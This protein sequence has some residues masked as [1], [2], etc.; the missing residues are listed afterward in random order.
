M[1]HQLGSFGFAVGDRWKCLAMAMGKG[2][3]RMIAL[4]AEDEATR[5][6]M[7]EKL[8]TPAWISITR[9]L[10]V[11]DVDVAFPR[12]A[13]STELSLKPMWQA[14]GVKS[15][16]DSTCDLS[17]LI[18]TRPLC[19]QEVFHHSTIEVTERGAEAAAATAAIDPFGSAPTPAPRASFVADKP[20]LWALEHRATGLILFMGRFAG[21]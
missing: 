9:A 6:R 18:N 14:M 19:V 13:F 12:F 7:E 4:L 16:F 8:D 5:K 17:G 20:F 1:M 2:E 3:L 11:C 21:R 15:V 10:A